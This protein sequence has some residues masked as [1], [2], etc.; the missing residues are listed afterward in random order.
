M[1]K[2]LM[3]I[4]VLSF[5]VLYG[6]T[7]S[8]TLTFDRGVERINEIDEKFGSSVKIPPA[9]TTEIDEL[10]T[11]I[12]GFAALNDD[13]PDSLKLLIDFRI[14]FLEA[15][16]LHAEG[17]QWGR[18]STTE[19]GF[20]CRRGLERITNSSILRI[21]AANKGYESVEVLQEFVDEFPDEAKS[22]NVT[23][24]DVLVL[25]AAYLTILE[26]AESDAAIVK[27]GCRKDK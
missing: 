14:K 5:V 15:E 17:W 22:I 20:G 13:M 26:K 19:F 6:C 10:L 16:R 4:F 2:L 3:V 8:G 25:N 21:A 1:S 27:S 24:I 18:A 9:T 11:Q 7:S 23:Q 12:I